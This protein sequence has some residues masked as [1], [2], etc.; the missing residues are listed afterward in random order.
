MASRTSVFALKGKPQDVRAIGALLDC[1]VVLEGTVRRSG[2]MLRITAQ[3]TSTDDGHLVWSQRYDRPMDDAFTIQD[4]IA[5]TIVNTLRTTSLADVTAPPLR[6]HTE[7][8]RAY[9]LY[10]KGRFEWNRRT[11]EGIVAGIR[12]FEQAIAE[13]PR[14]ALAYTGLAD[15]YSL[16]VD[17]RS[18]PVVDG[19]ESAKAYARKA[20]ELDDSLAEAH[21]S[22]AW[23]LFIY[24]WSWDEAEREFRRAVDLDPRYASAHQWFAFLLASK[25]ALG[26]ALIEGHTA[27]ELDPGSASARRSL[28]AAYF[29]ARRYDQARYHFERAIAMD[30]N[31]EEAYRMFGLTLAVA[32]QSAEAT[33]VLREAVAM[34]G[35]GSY[36]R[37]CLGYALA[38]DGR[39]PEARQMLDELSAE[40]TRQ[41]VSPV[42]FATLLLG[43]GEHD[44]ALDWAQR[45]MEERRGW[46]VYLNVNPMFDPLRGHPRFEELVRRMRLPGDGLRTALAGS[47]VTRH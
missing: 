26:E 1:L 27:V 46:L 32:G 31:S 34:P 16:H 10:L 4:E 23:A 17:Y 41:Y 12:Y 7:N 2:E 47:A 8:A 40:A 15:C 42:A 11:Q 5:R 43:L 39:E 36:T 22:L 45:A 18:V 13:D 9:S 6:R 19:L 30:P 20:I 21:A 14:Y 38:R 33:Q 44:R 28:G 25:G 37:A 3:L 35:A 24:D 29:Y